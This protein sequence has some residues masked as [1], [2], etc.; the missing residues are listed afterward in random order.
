[1]EY[2]VLVLLTKEREFLAIYISLGQTPHFLGVRKV[3]GPQEVYIRGLLSI[4]PKFCMFLA[5]LLEMK[6]LY[7]FKV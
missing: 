2:K 6:E 7:S 3:C 1:M 4:P 5:L